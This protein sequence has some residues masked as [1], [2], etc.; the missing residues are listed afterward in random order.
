M[1]LQGLWQGIEATPIAQYI[2]SSAWAFPTIEIVHVI[3]IVTVVGTIAVM[4]LRLIGV[5]SRECAVTEM[6]RDTLRWTWGAFVLAALTGGLLFISKATSYV[7]NPYFLWK[8]VL[9]VLAGANMAVFNFFT[10]RTVKSWDSNCAV[11]RAGKIAGGLSLG[12]WVA[13]VFVARAIGFTLD[14]FVAH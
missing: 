8:M 6:S 1:I 3:A 2:A 14:K 4:D 13:V 5:A 10:W 7:V 11:P 12:F 9:I